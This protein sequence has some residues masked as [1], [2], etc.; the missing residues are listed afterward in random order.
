MRDEPRAASLASAEKV[1]AEIDLI[2]HR[3]A[4]SREEAEAIVQA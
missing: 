1:L 4:A 3:A 2:A